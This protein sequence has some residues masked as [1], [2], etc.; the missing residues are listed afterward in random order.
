MR[1][2]DVNNKCSPFHKL[3]FSFRQTYIAIS[4]EGSKFRRKEN[5]YKDH[6]S[7]LVSFLWR[8]HLKLQ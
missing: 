1:L 3:S 2:Y 6:Q 7:Y 5:F 4:V 8:H